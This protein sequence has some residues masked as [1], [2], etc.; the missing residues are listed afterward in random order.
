MVEGTDAILYF[1]SASYSTVR[2]KT[3]PDQFNQLNT[4]N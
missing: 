4:A 1:H 3:E 2:A